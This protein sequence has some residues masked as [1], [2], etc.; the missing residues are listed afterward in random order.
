MKNLAIDLVAIGSLWVVSL[1]IV[2]P[3]GAFPLNDDWSYALT[4]KHL[5]ESGS[6]RPTGFTSMPLIAN[7]LWGSLFCLPAGFSFNA[8][9]LSTLT[10][11]ILGILGTYLLMRN[12]SQPR[13]FAAIVALTLGF[14]PIYYSMSNTFMTDVPFAAITILACLFFV[15]SMKTN[16]NLDYY[17]GTTFAVAA[18]LSRQLGVAVPLAFA[19]TLILKRGI[20]ARNLVRAAIPPALCT[21][22]LWGFQYWLAATGRLPALYYAKSNDL[23]HVLAGSKP[24]LIRFAG[25]NS[26]VILLYLG[27]FL[28]PVSLF[29][30]AAIFRCQK[31]KATLILFTSLTF[32]MVGILGKALHG[33][34]TLMPLADN[35]VSNYGI[36]PIESSNPLPTGFWVVVT[37]VSVVGAALL[38]TAI[39]LAAIK[40][41]QRVRQRQMNE[42]EAAGAFLLLSVTAY[43]L[44]LTVGGFFDRYLLP[45]IPLLTAGIA[46]VLCDY[47]RINTSRGLFAAV[48][49]LGALAFFSIGS[50][51]DYLAVNRVRWKALDDLLASKQVKAVDIDGGDEFN[52][53]SLYESKYP[54]DPQKDWEDAPHR[55]IYVI[56]FQSMAGYTVTKEYNYHHWLP[57]YS[58]KVLV[59]HKNALELPKK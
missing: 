25:Y 20:T 1:I 43:L 42:S 41:V 23:L 6:F 44:P 45:V 32:M 55:G 15:R 33:R 3:S 49:L 46:C 29:A 28:S 12:V 56:A 13:W 34:T 47:P 9:R 53:L 51:R 58:G 14:N 22:I 24:F 37:I 26:Y 40:V 57:P 50:T 18:T 59:L 38:I 35:I 30:L 36:G 52:G 11:S 31:K 39:V 10:L 54:Q 48:G 5:L 4:V 16:S 27:L 8:L 21:G 19:V 17:L 7:V 2:N